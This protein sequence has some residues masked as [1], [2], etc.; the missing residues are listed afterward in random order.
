MVF[1][2]QH[3]FTVS[4]SFLLLIGQRSFI[5]PLPQR[6]SGFPTTSFSQPQSHHVVK[7][8]DEGPEPAS[9]GLRG[10]NQQE[11]HTQSRSLDPSTCQSSAGWQALL[12]RGSRILVCFWGPRSTLQRFASG[13]GQAEGASRT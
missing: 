4:H 2:Q 13:W 9:R 7:G 12:R 1:N 5:A 11:I 8:R 3:P 10:M 6:C